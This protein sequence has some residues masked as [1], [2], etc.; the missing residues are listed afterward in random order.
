MHCSMSEFARRF[1]DLC[2][3]APNIEETLRINSTARPPLGVNCNKS[4]NVHA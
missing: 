4:E 3:Q 1:E 2:G